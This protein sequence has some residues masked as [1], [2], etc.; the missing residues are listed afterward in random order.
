[1]PQFEPTWIAS[2][3]FWL[4]IVFF[5]FYRLL[6]SRIVPNVAAI[7]AD[8]DARIQSDLELAQSRRDE[9]EAMRAAYEADL[10]R[11]RA[12]AQAELSAAQTRMAQQQAAALEQLSQ[13][14][15]AQTA[16]AEKRIAAEKASAMADIRSV[17]LDVASAASSRLGSGTVDQARI[18]AAIDSSMEAR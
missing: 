10:A 18:E 12:D 14:L 2:Q 4:V 8:R 3:I 16:D 17:A 1:M 9:L 7:M 6:K 11:A 5:I 15:A 13:E